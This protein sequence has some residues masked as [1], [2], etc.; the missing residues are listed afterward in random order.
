MMLVP[1]KLASQMAIEGPSILV[2]TLPEEPNI[3]IKYN[4][5]LNT[6]SKNNKCK[7]IPEMS[8]DPY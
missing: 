7:I 2:S 8:N 4:L 3:K 6:I 5:V 1:S